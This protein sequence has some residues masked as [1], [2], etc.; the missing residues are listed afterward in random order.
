MVRATKAVIEPAESGPSE[1]RRSDADRRFHEQWLGMVQ[2]IDGLVFSLPV[3]EEGHVAVR[4]PP[5]AQGRLID[6]CPL[7]GKGPERRI[8]AL[9]T[10]LEDVLGLGPALFD[11]GPALPDELSLWVPEGRQK[12][13]P[14]LAL[15]R[16]EPDSDPAGPHGDVRSS[17]EGG[18]DQ[19]AGQAA[20]DETLPDESTPHSRAGEPYLALVWQIPD[21]LA[22]DRAETVTGAW[23][24]PPA[25][26]F[27][28]LLRACRVP[29]GLLANG[30]ALR[31]V[32][33][34]HGE[35]LGSIT[36][37][38]DTL[39]SVGGR[40]VF[41]ALAELLSAGRIFFP[42]RE[43]S[44]LG[45]LEESRRRQANVTNE[46]ARQVY[47]ALSILLDGFAAAAERDGRAL[48]PKREDLYAGLL[49]V[50]LRIVFM[51]YAEDQRDPEGRGLLP[52]EHPLY[53]KH[54]SVHGLFGQLQAD[55]DRYPDTMDRRFGAW[56]R[57]VAAFRA[58]FDGAIHGEL[59]M[60]ARRGDLFDPARHPFL[61][62]WDQGPPVNGVERAGT[63]VPSVSDG[64]VHR[65][66]ER[67]LILGAGTGRDGDGSRRKGQRLAYR[68]LDVEQI[69]SVYERLMGYHVIRLAA[70]AVQVKPLRVWV[71]AEDLLA[72]PAGQRESHLDDEAGVPKALMKKAAAALRAA[73]TESAMLEA[74]G[75]LAG[76]GRGADAG[77][78]VGAAGRLVLQPG[79][80]RRR[81]SSH[82]TPRSLTEP[83]VRKTLE[84]LLSAMRAKNGGAEPTSEQIL[85]LKVCDPAMGSGAFLVAAC[86]FLA[87][88]VVAAW[89]RENRLDRVA[90]AA[91]D[92]TVLAR[93]LVAQRSLYGVD[94]N[95]FAV[96]LAKLSLWLTTLSRHEPFT[97][98][99]HALRHGD[100]LVGLSLAEIEAFDWTAQE[101]AA[102]LELFPIE[103]KTAIEEARAA[104]QQI[105]DLA[106]ESG[107]EVTRRKEALLR[108]ADDALDRAKLLGDLV[109]GAFFAHERDKDRRAELAR[110][111]AV[112]ER[113][114]KSDQ[115]RPDELVEMQRV[116]RETVPAFH[117]MLEFPEVFFAGRKELLGTGRRAHMDA[118]VGN[119]PFAGK[120]LT[121]ETHGPLYGEWL[122][123]IHIGS[124]GN[125][126]LSAHFF[127]RATILLGDH[128]TVGLLATN[129]IAQGDTRS[130][131]LQWLLAEGAV[132][133]DA[134]KSREWPG[135]SNVSYALVHLAKGDVVDASTARHLDGLPVACISSRLLATPERPD[136]L[137]LAANGSNRHQGS[138]LQGS[139]TLTPDEAT[140]LIADAHNAKCVFP[141]I[142]GLE[143]NT[144]P[145]QEFDRYVIDFRTRTLEQ[146]S[147]WPALLALVQARVKPEREKLG[148]NAVAKQAKKIWWRFW[149]P[150]PELYARLEGRKR[151]LVTAIVSKHVLFSF[152]PTNRV[153]SHKLYVFPG[154]D[155][156]AH[157]A[158]LQSRVHIDWAWLLSSTMRDAGINYSASDCF[159][160][161]PF[162]SA[163]QLGP[164]SA[165]ERIGETLDTTR[166]RIMCDREFG[167]TVLYN[168]LKDPT[169]EDEEIVALRAL[170]EEMDRAVL[171][172]YGWSDITVP[173][174]QEPVTRDEKRIRQAFSDEIIDRLFALNAERAAEERGEPAPNLVSMVGAVLDQEPSKRPRKAASKGVTRSG[175]CKGGHR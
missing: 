131:G 172:A 85:S 55:A 31:L 154:F 28:R 54:L 104:R 146:A 86:R 148:N 166:S 26:K 71:V 174:Y 138:I 33:A 95:P 150:R 52:V 113:W 116:T 156:C 58:I 124:H 76:K 87:D 175:K 72:V 127:R 74:L 143:V 120:N 18:A 103:V 106:G 173:P 67:L 81:T 153:F 169:C 25:A 112:V 7:L 44:L 100:S 15:R 125:A 1:G 51:L 149:A 48:D 9:E 89:T 19:D 23:H 139:F 136:P 62:G 142:G 17:G 117:W 63:K 122:K 45:L 53:E 43:R 49:T 82:Y 83:V 11:R 118:F 164:K 128:G 165:L 60:P 144:N 168:Q 77:S 107:D 132:I 20:Q 70:A 119:P 105:L 94:K 91:E 46:L 155:G 158:V 5:Q 32:Y 98:V 68:S 61:E 170:H 159:D 152:Q 79:K 92:A 141:Y 140:R 73:R 151:C 147:K 16:R 96:S 97:F 2:P 108:D 41:D 162:P 123:A 78:E 38:V 111:K 36:F 133:Y 24:Y 57:L 90:S 84:P 27:E 64:V 160:P 56:P 157:L 3:L 8:G 80:E 59:V 30:D 29:I 14:T 65:V 134:V 109:V 101:G 75:G 4:H 93:R 50:L 126:D 66:L 10:L 6:L 129:T 163:E 130:T 167:L 102:Q 42:A 47:D 22:F 135:D 35:S 69:G 121:T 40:S 88:Q 137:T 161:F 39:A 114:L 110:R 13:V 99:D 21:G 12:L 115:A 145:A 37:P 171:A 34:P